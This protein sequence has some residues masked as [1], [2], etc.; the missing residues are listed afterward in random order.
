[1]SI[2]KQKFDMILKLFIY[3]F[4]MSLLGLF[5]VSPFTYFNKIQIAAAVFSTLF[6][7]AL[8]CYA[9]IEDGQKDY[10]SHT[11]GRIKGKAYAGFLYAFYSYIPTIVIVFIQVVLM[12]FTD[13]NELTVL[14]VIL[15][16]LI[17]IFLMGMYLGFDSGFVPRIPD[18]I[19]QQKTVN[20]PDWL[21]YMSDNYLIFA[22][23]LILTPV[24]CGITYYLAF[25]GKVHV[26][27]SVKTKKKK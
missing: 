1:M 19:T 22:C 27:T 24:V 5:V 3:Q 25:T 10:I 8:V 6:Y 17:R 13:T 12:L 14:K 7:F 23:F 4:A 21:V 9:V 16:F 20:V 15:G 18:E 11:A 2:Y 26:D